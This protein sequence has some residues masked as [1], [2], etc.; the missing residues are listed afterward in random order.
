MKK[1]NFDFY[2][3]REI[4]KNPKLKNEF[5]RADVAIDISIQI[6][7]L[8]KNRGMTQKDLAKLTGVKQSNVA[9]LERADYEGYSLKTLNKVAKALKTILKISLIPEEEKEVKVIVNYMI[10]YFSNP[11]YEVRIRLLSNEGINFMIPNSK[12]SEI[13]GETRNAESFAYQ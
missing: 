10:Y 11:M 3:G 2:I 8:R 5:A 13:Q 12:A 9:R 4:R 6:Y 7:E 1:T